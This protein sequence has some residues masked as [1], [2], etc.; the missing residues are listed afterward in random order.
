[1]RAIAAKLKLRSAD[2]RG[3]A[4]ATVLRLTDEL[5]GL[6]ERSG[7]DAGAVLSNARR[8]LRQVV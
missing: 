3:G 1:M 5:A 6:A 7:H 4:Q 8:A 2:G